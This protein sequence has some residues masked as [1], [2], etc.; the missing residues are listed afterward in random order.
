MVKKALLAG[1]VVGVLGIILMPLVSSAAAIEDSFGFVDAVRN[2]AGIK[3]YGSDLGGFILQ[4]LNAVLTVVAVIAAA[5]IIYAGI[6]LISDMGDEENVEKAKK[7]IL[8]AVIG[9]IVIGL[10]ATLVNV[11]VN[12]II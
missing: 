4:I 3:D 12:F 8:Y 2:R 11:V 1:V 10:S 9:L 5:A 7:I 6:L